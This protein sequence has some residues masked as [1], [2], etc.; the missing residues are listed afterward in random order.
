[1]EATRSHCLRSLSRQ[2]PSSFGRSP[3]DSRRLLSFLRGHQLDKPSPVQS[4]DSAS[5][6]RHSNANNNNKPGSSTKDADKHLGSILDHPLFRIVP[7]KPLPRRDER[8]GAKDAVSVKRKLAENPLG[9]LDELMASGRADHNT[10]YRC[11]EAHRSLSASS[12]SPDAVELS[13]LG[14][15]IVAWYSAAHYEARMLFFGSRPAMTVVMPYIIADHLQDVVI[16][17]VTT[18]YKRT[19]IEPGQ[20][21]SSSLLP[22]Q[23][24]CTVNVLR[25]FFNAEIKYGQGIQSALRYFIRICELLPPGEK[26]GYSRDDPFRSSLRTIGYHLV[27]WISTHSQSSE[28]QGMPV[29]LYEEF[30]MLSDEFSKSNGFWGACLRLHH[31]TSPDVK[32]VLSYI[33]GMSETK[34]TPAKRKHLLRLSFDAAQ[35]CLEHKIYPEASWLLTHA[36][37]FIVDEDFTQKHSSDSSDSHAAIGPESLFGGMCLQ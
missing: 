36:R 10:L 14:S 18:L 21:L 25:N 15:R 11:L 9:L 28:V 5:R 30:C 3:Q 23:R 2:C 22:P 12:N 27:A 13:G 8:D 31:P 26:F 29:S 16:D 1:M 34:S 19:S 37:Q 7:D 35:F 24:V 33:E 6:N 17:W 4:T 20:G 32:P